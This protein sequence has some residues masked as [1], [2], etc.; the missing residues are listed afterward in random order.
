MHKSFIFVI[1][2]KYCCEH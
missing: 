1:N 2:L